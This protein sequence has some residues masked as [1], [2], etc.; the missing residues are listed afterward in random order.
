MATLGQEDCNLLIAAKTAR[1]VIVFPNP[2]LG[3]IML[4]VSVFASNIIIGIV[5][6]DCA[7]RTAQWVKFKSLHP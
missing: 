6:T 1:L 4:V 5:S 7:G 3:Q 2:I